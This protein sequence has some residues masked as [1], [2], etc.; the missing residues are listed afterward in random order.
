MEQGTPII[1]PKRARKTFTGRFEEFEVCVKIMKLLRCKRIVKFFQ[2][3]RLQ[4]GNSL[5]AS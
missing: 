3:F 1:S 2:R 4:F 5:S